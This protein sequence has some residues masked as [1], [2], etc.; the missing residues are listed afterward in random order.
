MRALGLDKLTNAFGLTAL[1]MGLGVFIGTTAGGVLNDLTGS[2]TAAFIFAGIC[3]C[4]SG[5]LKLLLPYLLKR[6]K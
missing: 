4:L 2:Y 1:A 5:G 6:P 3:I